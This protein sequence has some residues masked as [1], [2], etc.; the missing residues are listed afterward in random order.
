[1]EYLPNGITLTVP[2]GVF[3]LSTDT[4]VL[5]DFVRLPKNARVLDIGSGCGT[6]GLL[7]CARDPG[8]HVTGIEFSPAAHSAAVENIQTNAIDHRLESLCA[9]ARL[10]RE[11]VAPGYFHVCVSNP[12]YFSGGP[13]SAR[14]PDAR[15]EDTL[16]AEDLMRGAAWALKTGGDLFIVHRPEKLGQLIA[17][18]SREGLEAKRL[19]LIKHRS[20][21]AVS[22]ILLQLRKG[23]KPGLLLEEETLYLKDGSK[24][25]YYRRIYH[26]E[27]T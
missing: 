24:S 18:G 11:I 5:S 12:P 2:D 19:R 15:R 8:C 22:L 21:G 17:A 1:M 13:S 27:E 9:D 7:L 25:P 23:A 6:L 3:P 14:H 26:L 16:K 10:L 20:G 4:I